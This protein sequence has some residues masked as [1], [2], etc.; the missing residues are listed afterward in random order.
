MVECEAQL[1]RIFA[2]LSDPI[3][4]DMLRRLVSGSAHIGQLAQNY[5]ISFAAVAKHL[6]VL[7]LAQLISKQ[8]QGK[9]VIVRIA[10]PALKAASDYLA[11]YEALWNQ[12]F[13]NLEK[14][15]QEEDS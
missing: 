9:Q 6:Q 4:R 7:E 8:R 12:R 11:Q 10:P 3:R 5:A 2:C 14:L 1:D 13:D 15:L